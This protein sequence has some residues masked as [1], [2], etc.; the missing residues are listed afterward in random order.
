ML[1]GKKAKTTHNKSLL[2]KRAPT[3]HVSFIRAP[4]ILGIIIPCLYIIV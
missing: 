2:L 3:I 4:C 1:S